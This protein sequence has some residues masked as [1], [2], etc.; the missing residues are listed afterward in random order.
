MGWRQGHVGTGCPQ[1][2]PTSCSPG[3]SGS[4]QDAQHVVRLASVAGRR[5]TDDV[6]VEIGGLPPH[7]VDAALREAFAQLVLVP[8][9][10]PA[11]KCGL[12][13]PARTAAGG[14]V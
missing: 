11:R 9:V 1:D 4:G 7:E 2:W 12:R 5:V 6:L 8:D 3:W 10:A 13:V 14:G